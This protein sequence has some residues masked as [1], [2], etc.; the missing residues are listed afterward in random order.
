M[1]RLRFSRI[2]RPASVRRA[3]RRSSS[4]TL[5]YARRRV[6]NPKISDSARRGPY[7]RAYVFQVG[8]A[9]A[10]LMFTLLAAE[11]LPRLDVA[12]AVLISAMASTAF[13]LFIYP[14][15]T[16]ADPRHV[17]G[18]HAVA[19]AVASPLAAFAHTVAG[20]GFLEGAP[21]LFGFYAATAVGVAI[22]LMA[23]IGT[24]HP[25]AAGTALAFVVH[26][27]AWD[28]MAFVV[29]G[30]LLMSATHRILRSRI[31]DL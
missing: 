15:S 30:V 14:H 26:G 27:F 16:H 4:W 9:A 13:V 11:L 18:G 17:I 20:G 19:I 10:A 23:L 21:L 5:Q 3:A 1:G 25:P 22:L 2:R 28:W 7:F 24:E 29:I 8:L 6:L 12:E 31:H